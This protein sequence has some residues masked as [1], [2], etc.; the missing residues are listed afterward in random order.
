MSAYDTVVFDS[1]GVLVTPP[2]YETQAAATVIAFEELGVR[3]VD[4]QVID[5]IVTGVAVDRLRDICATYGLDP[6]T[7]WEVW[8]RHDEQSQ[9]AQFRTGA[10]DRYDDVTI[11]ETLS[12]R[13]GVVSNNHHSTIAFV[14]DFFDLESL[15]DTYYGR[16]K[17][18]RSLELQKPNTHY[19]DRALSELEAT[20]ALYVG[21]SDSDVVAA[22][23]AGMDSVFVRRPHC[24]DVELTMSP[25]YEVD[26]LEAVVGIVS[27]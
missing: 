12:Q 21:D 10:R 26:T 7:F 2:A 24:R 4:R 23:R 3:D 14:L 13:C 25:T 17:T 1:D 9:L 22:A 6:E 18:L 20:S 16:E 5:E 15:F 27:D 11:I 19:L 8:E